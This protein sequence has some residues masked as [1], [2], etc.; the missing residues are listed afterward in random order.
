MPADVMSY[1][2]PGLKDSAVYTAHYG[3]DTPIGKAKPFSRGT[4]LDKA[5]EAHTL[6]AYAMNGRLLARQLAERQC[7]SPLQP[8]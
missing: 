2:P 6:I 4:S 3:D 5:M 8:K 7:T 1:K